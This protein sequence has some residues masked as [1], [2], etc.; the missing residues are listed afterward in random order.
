MPG[1]VPNEAGPLAS[2][3]APNVP[4]PLAYRVYILRSLPDTI[5]ENAGQNP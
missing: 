3:N 2:P 4:S 1:V 5:I